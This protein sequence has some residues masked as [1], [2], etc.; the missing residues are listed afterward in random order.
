MWVAPRRARPGGKEKKR[1]AAPRRERTEP[2]SCTA[3]VACLREMAANL[4]CTSHPFCLRRERGGEEHG[5]VSHHAVHGRARVPLRERFVSFSAS[6]RLSYLPMTSSLSATSNERATSP[7]SVSCTS[8]AT[9]D[10]FSFV[11][12]GVEYRVD[13]AAVNGARSPR[14]PESL[15]KNFAGGISM[16][17]LSRI[18]SMVFVEITD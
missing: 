9:T 10:I 13:D 5:R 3:R 12:R 4:R 17:V 8:L 15:A 1:C 7:S 2:P 18:R 6:R 16:S 14:A 11:H